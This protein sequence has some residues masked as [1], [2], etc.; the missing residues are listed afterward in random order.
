MFKV[1]SERVGHGE[2]K[3][4]RLESA[5]QQ[6]KKDHFVWFGVDSARLCG[7]LPQQAVSLATAGY[8]YKPL[9]HLLDGLPL[10]SR[11]VFTRNPITVTIHLGIWTISYE[12]LS[13]GSGRHLTA[14]LATI[15]AK[16][17]I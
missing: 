4:N 15:A 16:R 17:C 14:M 7:K 5:E 2:P 12:K 9:V 11:V 6:C 13:F 3:K 8:E 1:Q 10:K